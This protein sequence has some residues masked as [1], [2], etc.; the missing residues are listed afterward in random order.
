[1]SRLQDVPSMLVIFRGDIDMTRDSA[2]HI[3]QSLL[4][5]TPARDAAAYAFH[6]ATDKRPEEKIYFFHED[7]SIINQAQYLDDLKQYNGLKM[8]FFQRAQGIH[9]PAQ[10]GPYLATSQLVVE[11]PAAP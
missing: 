6:E 5:K 11:A 8:T 4:D 7:A 10:G 9:V 1:M 2:G 3:L